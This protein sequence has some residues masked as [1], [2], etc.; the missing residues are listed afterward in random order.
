MSD[1]PHHITQR[2]NN[3]QDVFFV[4]DDRRVYLEFLKKQSDR[5]GVEVQ[6]Y[7]LMTNHVHL[8]A[9]PQNENSLA[10]AVGIT[11]LLYTQYINRMHGRSGHL[12]QN[13][14]YSCPLDDE[15]F[16]KAL[17]YIECNPVRA[18]LTGV[19]WN[20]QWSSAGLHIGERDGAG[21]IDNKQWQDISTG[22]QWKQILCQAQADD[23][24]NYIRAET[25]RGRPLGSDNF[26]SKLERCL[27]RRI[28]PL[29]VGRPKRKKLDWESS[30]KPKKR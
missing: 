18:K 25:Y 30:E 15:H 23:E 17:R 29:P 14:F 13:R 10:K 21:L 22:M 12:W 28:R 4:D 5:F 11:H 20:Y 24:I 1:L 2:G 26:T 27:G 16:W 6:G 7:C 8:I 19:A 3:H 9:T